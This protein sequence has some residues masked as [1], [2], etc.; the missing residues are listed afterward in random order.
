MRLLICIISI[1]FVSC[2]G[3]KTETAQ[4]KPAAK[5]VQA[6]TDSNTLQDAPSKEEP[7]VETES[8][9]AASA[10]IGNDCFA[11]VCIELRNHNPSAKTFEIHM[12]NSVPVA[13]FQCDLPGIKINKANG[14]RLNE[15]GFEV[16]NSESRILA[17]S[18]QAK[19]IPEGEGVLT[20]IS[21]ENPGNEVCMTEIIF[22]GI[23]GVKVSNNT[24][25]CM[26]L[27]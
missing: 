22:A 24:P 3:K 20:E 7:A 15:N 18:M 27:N 5:R 8:Q 10:Q 12:L 2:Q 26:S 6:V 17:F 16:S 9:V 21:Y 11:E 1:I 25:G 13:G 14:G 23:G 19:V 4:E